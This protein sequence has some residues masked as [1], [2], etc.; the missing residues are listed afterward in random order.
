MELSESSSNG[1]LLGQISLPKSESQTRHTPSRLARGRE[2]AAAFPESTVRSEHLA[3]MATAT[4]DDLLAPAEETS[5]VGGWIG[6][7]PRGVLPTPTTVRRRRNIARS[8]HLPVTATSDDLP[9]P[10]E[11]TSGVGGWIGNPNPK[12]TSNRGDE[13]RASS[14]RR[15]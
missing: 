12:C 9:A 6:S 11:E 5:S 13:K 2:K 15:L 3:A 10:A 8:G 14:T 4:A 7:P 1:I